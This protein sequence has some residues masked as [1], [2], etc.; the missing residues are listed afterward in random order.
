ME[1]ILMDD[2]CMNFSNKEIIDFLVEP[3]KQ[4]ECLDIR[5]V[6]EE[7]EEITG[8]CEKKIH[9]ITFDGEINKTEFYI[10]FYEDLINLFIPYSYAVECLSFIDDRQKYLLRS[11][12]IFERAIY[13]GSLTDKTTEEIMDLLRQ[14]VIVLAGATSIKARRRVLNQNAKERSYDLSDYIIKIT[15][16][17]GTKKEVTFENIKFIINEHLED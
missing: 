14:F 4:Y 11:E 17:S 7:D 13:E 12:D 2:S 10:I 8:E 1:E 16:D 6:S 5:I 3:L 9:Y 15:N